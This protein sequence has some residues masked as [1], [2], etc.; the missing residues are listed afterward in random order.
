[1]LALL[2]ASSCWGA[3]PASVDLGFTVSSNYKEVEVGCLPRAWDRGPGYLFGPV[4]LGLG[5]VVPSGDHPNGVRLHLDTLG[6]DRGPYV[7][8]GFIVSAGQDLGTGVGARLGAG[9]RWR[10]GVRVTVLADGVA[11]SRKSEGSVGIQ[12]AYT[13]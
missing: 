4:R 13:F 11:G 7:L 10:Q 9:Y 3:T 12:A 2:A 6:G 1:L 8:A 5:L